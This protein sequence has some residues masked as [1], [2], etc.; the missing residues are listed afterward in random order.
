M[1]FC[2]CFY[3]YFKYLVGNFTL[4]LTDLAAAASAIIPGSKMKMWR[5]AAV[6]CGG[7][8][9]SHPRGVRLPI[10]PKS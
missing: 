9:P 4:A 7:A 2:F 6:R 10:A 5:R 3:N 8:A 1:C